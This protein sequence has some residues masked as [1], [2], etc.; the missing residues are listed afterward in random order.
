MVFKITDYA[1]KLLD[2]LE[3]LDWPSKTVAMQSNWI[4]R[5]EGTE[6]EFA[7]EGHDWNF[8]VFTTRPDTLFGVTYV[9]F[10]PEHQK[11]LEITTDEQRD[12]V[13]DYIEQT[14][15][16]KEVDRLSTAKEKTGVFTGAYAIN[17]VNGEK[18]PIWISDY[19]LVTYGTGVVMGVPGHDERDF[20]FAEAFNLPCRKVIQEPNTE[21]SS[22]LKS[23]YTEPGIVLNSGK[24]DG[25]N[26]L[27]MKTKITNDLESNG[28][29]QKKV[30]FRLRDWLV[31]RQRYWGAP[32][33][34]INCPNCGEVLVPED[35]LPVLLPENV[36]FK[37]TGES[38]LRNC[39]E[40]YH[41]TCPKCGGPATREV[42]TLDT[43]LFVLVG[44]IC[45]TQMLTIKHRHSIRI[46]LIKCY[47]LINTLEVQSTLVCIYYMLVL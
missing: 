19:V 27:E 14:A 3:T 45:D 37:P 33:P 1:E 11:V 8:K 7:M 15:K 47:R 17:P 32:I 38:P 31:S 40:F 43:F 36:E 12:S 21:L 29:G 2:N 41:T 25:M 22:I 23:A 30:N 46:L 9:T 18:I 20:A 16:M 42:D 44:I 6:I 4:G 26:S 10:A 35:Q 39:E 13:Q 24:Y 5:S 34:I 28:K